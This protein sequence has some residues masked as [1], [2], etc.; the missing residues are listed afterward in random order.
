MRISPT[1]TLPSALDKGVVIKA[2][3]DPAKKI[4][5]D[6]FDFFFVDEDQLW[7]IIG[8]V[9]RKGTSGTLLTAVLKSLIRS[10]ALK[11]EAPATIVTKVNKEIREGNYAEV[12]ITL[13]VGILNTNTNKFVYTNASHKPLYLKRND[14]EIIRFGK[15]HGTTVGSL[16]KSNYKEDKLK[17]YQDETV[18]L[19]TDGLSDAMD[20]DNRLFSD[21]KIANVFSSKKFSS[22]DNLIDTLI[23]T[24]DMF[25]GEAAL[26]DDVTLLTFRT[27]N[28]DNIRVSS[29]KLIMRI[30]NE[31]DQIGTVSESFKLFAAHNK[32]SDSDRQ[33]IA[34]SMDELLN[35]IISYGF[36]DEKL[37]TI[38]IIIELIEDGLEVTI[39]D[40]GMKFNPWAKESPDTL[41][42][43]E[44]REIG[45]LGIHM[46]ENLMDVVGYRRIKNKNINSLVKLK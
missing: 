3:M 16:E 9:S 2:Y 27:I 8:D 40:D 20:E 35:N 21:E 34:V 23:S 33:K 42:S 13:I 30:N 43:M 15:S 38:E 32:L 5:G 7:I 29:N 31:L 11:N 25:L 28:T 24:L 26:S 45:G 1:T 41:E 44:E 46:V 10:H 22:L 12:S 17:L 36:Q 39:I 37:H 18:L 6:F 19:F 14:G 4:G